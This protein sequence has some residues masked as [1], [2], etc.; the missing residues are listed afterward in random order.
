MHCRLA[1]LSVPPSA[2]GTTWSTS[3]P[4]LILPAALHGWHRPASRSITC[5]RSACHRLP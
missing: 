3:L 1:V 5:L 4:A 2:F